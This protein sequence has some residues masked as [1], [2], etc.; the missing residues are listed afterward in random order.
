MKTPVGSQLRVSWADSSHFS[1]ASARCAPIGRPS[2]PPYRQQQ[3]EDTP[4]SLFGRIATGRAAETS[5]VAVI[6]RSLSESGG[7]ISPVEGSDPILDPRG[8]RSRRSRESARAST[9]SSCL[10]FGRGP[11]AGRKR[12]HERHGASSAGT[13]AGECLAAI[14]RTGWQRPNSK[15]ALDGVRGPRTGRSSH[16]DRRENLERSLVAVSVDARCRDLHDMVRP[17]ATALIGKRRRSSRPGS[18]RPC[19]G[20]RAG[21]CVRALADEA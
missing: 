12:S 14:A 2:P 4:S 6:R 18:T 17:V 9:T 13:M 3:G 11:G 5:H 19:D 20:S 1:T 8:P 16:D 21:R 7:S 10:T 15:K